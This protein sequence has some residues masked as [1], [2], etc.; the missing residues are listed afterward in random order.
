VAPF[1]GRDHTGPR[2]SKQTDKS[3]SHAREKLLNRFMACPV[4]LDTILAEILFKLNT[5]SGVTSSLTSHTVVSESALRVCAVWRRDRSLTP[6]KTRD[7][8]RRAASDL[9]V[10]PAGSEEV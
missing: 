9:I 6:Y 2:S 1:D 7:F 5:R 10:S 3:P 4:E 8:T